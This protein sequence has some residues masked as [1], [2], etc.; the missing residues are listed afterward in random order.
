MDLHGALGASF[1]VGHRR[2]VGKKG[3]VQLEGAKAPGDFVVPTRAE[4]DAVDRLEKIF[5]P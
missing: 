4:L 2:V 1:V 5:K 3:I